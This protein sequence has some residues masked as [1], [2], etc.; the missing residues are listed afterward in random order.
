MG[1]PRTTG[2]V[3][4]RVQRFAKNADIKIGSSAVYN[5]DQRSLEEPV[6]DHYVGEED[7]DRN[8]GAVWAELERQR[9]VKDTAVELS[10]DHGFFLGEH[11]F[12]ARR[13]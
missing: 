9:K 12:S 1:Q 2:R 11:H 8:V 5:D 10:S 4:L 6:K 7:N 3:A 13:P